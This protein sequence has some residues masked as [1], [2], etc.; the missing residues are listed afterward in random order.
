M[1]ISGS[2]TG[3]EIRHPGRQQ[4]RA[5]PSKARAQPL[6]SSLEPRS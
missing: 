5:T 2:D 1:G 4:L 3:L 6:A